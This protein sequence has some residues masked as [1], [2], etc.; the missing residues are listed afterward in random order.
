[1]G[2]QVLAHDVAKRV[3]QLHGLDEEVVLG[4]DAG[5]AVGVLEVEAEPLLDAQALQAGVLAARSIKRTRSSASGA[6]RMESRQRK[7]TL[8]CMG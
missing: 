6:A 2:D 7:S 3:L 4:V 8:S 1:M 5:G